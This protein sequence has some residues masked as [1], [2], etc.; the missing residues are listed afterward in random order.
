MLKN[1]RSQRD[2][3]EIVIFYLN[4]AA[5]PPS[6][7]PAPLNAFPFRP[8]SQTEILV[9]FDCKI[10]EHPENNFYCVSIS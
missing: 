10:L 3:W 6:P 7:P 2:K 4:P 1:I 8:Y 5:P 9:E